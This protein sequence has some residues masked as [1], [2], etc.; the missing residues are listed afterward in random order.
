MFPLEAITTQYYAVG[1]SIKNPDGLTSKV[2]PDGYVPIA[3][4]LKTTGPGDTFA[5]VNI[6]V[7]G[8]NDVGNAELV[9]VVAEPPPD[10]PATYVPLTLFKVIFIVTYGFA[11]PE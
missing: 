2:A 11:A 4:K 5:L 1:H 10:V 8:R 3:E 6:E 7:I 9:A